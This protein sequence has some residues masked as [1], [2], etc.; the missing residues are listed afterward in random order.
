MVDTAVQTQGYLPLSF[1]S[2]IFCL[3]EAAINCDGKYIYI[4][5]YNDRISTVTLLYYLC[6]NKAHPR[7]EAIFLQLKVE[8]SRMIN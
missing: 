4:Y 8:Q 5:I 7:L 6:K 1:I 3:S 2:D